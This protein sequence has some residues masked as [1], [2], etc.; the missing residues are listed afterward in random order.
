[1]S[2]S[3][4][5]RR[6]LAAGLAAVTAAAVL[7]G[8]ASGKSSG[9]GSGNDS[10]ILTSSGSDRDTQ[11]QAAAVKEGTLN[12]TTSLAGPV[13]DDIVKAFQAKYPAIKVTVNRGDESTIIPQTVQEIQAKKS[14]P[15]VFEVTASGCLEF[16]DAG[17]LQPYYSPN[18]ADIAAEYKTTQG[19]DNLL[20]TDR[21]SYISFGYNTSKVPAGDV[22]KSLEDLASPALAGKLAIET[23]TTSEEWV[24]AVLHKL[25]QSAGEE[26]LQKLAQQ[27]V[28][29]TSLSGSALM[30]LVASGQYAASPSVFHNHEQQYAAKGSPVGWVPLDPVIAN[31]GQLGILKNASHPASALLF[32]DYLTGAE[33]QKVLEGQK[34][35]PPEEKQPFTAW[36]PSAGAKNANSYN[37]QLTGWAALQKKYFS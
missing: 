33:G 27:K 5:R 35:S 9:S 1:M 15:D 11:L 32:I 37:Q 19:D 6:V 16:K 25:G 13:V 29:Q 30:G 10:A 17:V 21:I 28:A 34:Y 23:D 2:R 3:S 31:I 18:A 4:D 26:F 36:V 14:S 20:L 22:P 7:A 24:G 12:W 8:C